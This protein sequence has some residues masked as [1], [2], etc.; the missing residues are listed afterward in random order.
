VGELLGLEAD[1]GMEL[2]F[3][4]LPVLWN[5]PP[6]VDPFVLLASPRISKF[7]EFEPGCL[8]TVDVRVHTLCVMVLGVH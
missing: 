8:E 1:L 2:N 5:L 4:Q 7:D 6:A 3:K